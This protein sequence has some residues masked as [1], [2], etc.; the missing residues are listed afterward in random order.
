MHCLM[1][2]S[3]SAVVDH[4]MSSLNKPIEYQNLSFAFVMALS[5][6]LGI[7]KAASLPFVTRHPRIVGISVHPSCRDFLFD[8]AWPMFIKF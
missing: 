2:F 6:Y 3:S 1:L 7:Y 8:L 4:V 5:H